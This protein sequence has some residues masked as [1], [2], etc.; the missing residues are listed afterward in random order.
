MKN[1]Y[2]GSLKSAGSVPDL[3][4]NIKINISKPK[5]KKKYILNRDKMQHEAG[6]LDSFLGEIRSTALVESGIL[7]KK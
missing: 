4:E 1:G 6:T 7:P 5:T 2:L 3:Q